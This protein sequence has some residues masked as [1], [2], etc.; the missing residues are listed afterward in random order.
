MTSEADNTPRK[1]KAPAATETAPRQAAKPPPPPA[2]HQEPTTGDELEEEDGVMPL[3]SAPWSE[4][5]TVDELDAV[6][7][8]AIEKVGADGRPHRALRLRLHPSTRTTHD[9]LNAQLGGGKYE[10]WAIRNKRFLTGYPITWPGKPRLADGTE[11][12]AAGFAQPIIETT[13]GMIGVAGLSPHEAREHTWA[14]QQVAYAR[15][16]YR[17]Q[18]KTLAEVLQGRGNNDG[19][20]KE[21]LDHYKSELRRVEKDRDDYRDK[22]AKL[23]EENHELKLE[24]LT[25]K[26][27]NK[28]E[29][30]EKLTEAAL[31][32]APEV[33]DLV[34]QLISMIANGKKALP[35]GT[36]AK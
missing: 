15:E 23:T 20:S 25:L 2:A 10:I 34:K 32:Q 9:D 33:F 8:F 11:A 36:A 26:F 16:D 29:L 14:Q 27:K 5:L 3:F 4:P 12:T 31:E 18:V 17:L 6:H 22:C 24:M 28:S 19:A 7:V 1:R 30:G 35:D 21:A 13:S